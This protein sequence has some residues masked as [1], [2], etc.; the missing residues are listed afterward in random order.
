M[1]K[2][3]KL[4]EVASVQTGLAL[5]RADSDS[6]SGAL[7]P[8]INLR[9][10]ESG[11]V[12]PAASLAVSSCKSRFAAERS[13]VAAGDVLFACRGTI[14]K[15]AVA[16][17]DTAGASASSNF[18]IVRPGPQILPG[19]LAAIL[20]SSKIQDTLKTHSRSIGPVFSISARD[21]E[22]LLIPVPPMDAQERISSL[23]EA[24]EENYRTALSSAESRRQIGYD[25]AESMLFNIQNNKNDAALKHSPAAEE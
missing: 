19:V 12:A 24:V 17:P 22:D 15:A 25:L 14:L 13:R 7:I 4:S 9:D 11:R 3:Q 8:V 21:V 18:L 1:S 23:L 2:M 10:V 6:R 20:Q 5:S 16:G